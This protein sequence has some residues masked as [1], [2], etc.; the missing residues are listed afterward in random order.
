MDNSKQFPGWMATVIAPVGGVS[1]GDPL[2]IG[3]SLFGVCAYDAAAGEEVEIQTLGSFELPKEA[4]LVISAGDILY[5]DSTA[6][7]LNKTASGNLRVGVARFDAA[8]ADETVEAHIV[9]G[10]QPTAP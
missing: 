1:T 7:E 10:P 8:S 3:E 2:Q 4:P 9:P 5:F 6:G